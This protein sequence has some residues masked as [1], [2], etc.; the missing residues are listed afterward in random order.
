MSHM[1]RVSHRT[2]FPAL[3][4]A[5]AGL[6]FGGPAVARDT[7]V[8]VGQEFASCLLDLQCPPLPDCEASQFNLIGFCNADCFP[9]GG[10]PFCGGLAGAGTPG[11]SWTAGGLFAAFVSPGGD[12]PDVQFTFEATATPTSPEELDLTGYIELYLG[13]RV[14]FQSGQV[15]VSVFRFSGDPTVFDGLDVPSVFVLS[16]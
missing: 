3:A 2:R 7:T 6:V 15:E 1:T 4:V 12:T 10:P 9:G 8:I 11:D 16:A 13:Y 14:P 5:V